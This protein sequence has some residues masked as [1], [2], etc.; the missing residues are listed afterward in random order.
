MSSYNLLVHFPP[1]L[2]TSGNLAIPTV[3]L[4]PSLSGL[5]FSLDW[6][7]ACCSLVLGF[8]LLS[9]WN[10]LS[11]SIGIYS[12]CPG[13]E[14]FL[15]LGLFSC[16]G[17]VYSPVVS[18]VKKKKRKKT[19]QK[20]LWKQLSECLLHA[21]GCWSLDQLPFYAWY[22]VVILKILFASLLGISPIVYTSCVPLSWFIFSFW[23]IYRVGS[24]KWICKKYVGNHF[25]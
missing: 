4:E 10:C 14:A 11:L 5:L 22:T 21:S 17:V 15:F 16:T 19:W 8:P 7:W 13:S 3:C 20:A 18:Q 1:R 23:W 9:T 24:W 6:C 2:L 25:L 12:L